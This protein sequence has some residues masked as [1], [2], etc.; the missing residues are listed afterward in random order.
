MERQP[1]VAHQFYAGEPKTLAADLS[2]L[3]PNIPEESREKA[4]AVV[5]PHAG[6]VYSGAVAGETIGRVRIPKTVLLLGPNHHGRGARAALAASSAWRM[7]LG[8]VPVEA[9]LSSLLTEKCRLL[10]IDDAAHSHE[11]SLEV[12]IPFLQHLRPDV[13]IVPISLSMLPFDQCEEIG[14][15]IA[16]AIRDFGEEVLILASTDMTHYESRQ[17][18]GQKDGLAISRVLA[19]DPAGL[20]ETVLGSRITMCGIIPTTI[21]LIAAKALGACRANLVR[22]TDSGAVSGDIRQVVGY[23]GFVVQA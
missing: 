6:Y 11:H 1:A 18:A 14:L 2:L 22:Y 5:C 7:P 9:R 3:I 19:L 20:Y 12:Q 15:A 23:A 10:A 16:A 8:L 17:M 4:V 21:A 13:E